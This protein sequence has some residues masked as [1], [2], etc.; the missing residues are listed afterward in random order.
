MQVELDARRF[1]GNS[2]FLFASL[3]ERFLALYCN[4]NSFTRL[5]A[6]VR[7]REGVLRRW[8]PR[9]GDRKLV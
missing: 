8:Q 2:V 9:V 7:G 1:T 6:S 4:V 5:V 3:L